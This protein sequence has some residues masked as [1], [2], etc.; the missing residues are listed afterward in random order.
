MTH[1]AKLHCYVFT[2]FNH[3]PV[4][5]HAHRMAEAFE[6]FVMAYGNKAFLLDRVE[7]LA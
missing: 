2:C 7:T 4:V 1:K 3:P 6:M 5:I